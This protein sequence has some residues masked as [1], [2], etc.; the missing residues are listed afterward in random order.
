[1]TGLPPDG[2]PPKSAQQEEAVLEIT[3]VSH[4]DFS[5]LTLPNDP[6]ECFFPTALLRHSASQYSE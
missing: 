4:L 6:S 3:L 2:S 5:A 1:M